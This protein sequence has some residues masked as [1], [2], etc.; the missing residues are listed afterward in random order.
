M[1]MG[2]HLQYIA[3]KVDESS[4]GKVDYDK[5]EHATSKCF[6]SFRKIIGVAVFFFCVPGG[7]GPF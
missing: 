2:P 5:L 6:A 1:A 3:K 4:L 7:C